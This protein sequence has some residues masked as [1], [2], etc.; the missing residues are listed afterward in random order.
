MCRAMGTHAFHE[1]VLVLIYLSNVVPCAVV[2]LVELL[3]NPV[4]S[5]F[6]VLSGA[7]GDFLFDAAASSTGN[8]VLCVSVAPFS[9]CIMLSA[10]NVI[11]STC[12]AIHSL[13]VKVYL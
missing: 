1:N 6:Q 10:L 12:R 13:P 7:L 5:N 4:P 11:W 3:I 2:P 8:L 9:F